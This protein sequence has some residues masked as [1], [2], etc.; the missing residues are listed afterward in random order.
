MRGRGRREGEMNENCVRADDDDGDDDDLTISRVDAVER[1]N[2][3]RKR[4][5]FLACITHT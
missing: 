2:E 1:E 3:K 5:D 4:R